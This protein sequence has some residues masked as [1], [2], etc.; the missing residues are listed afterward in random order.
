MGLVKY[1][2]VLVFI[3]LILAALIL[4][5][6]L[7]QYF[8]VLPEKCV[9]FGP[10]IRWCYGIWEKEFWKGIWKDLSYQRPHDLLTTKYYILT[11]YVR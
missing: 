9:E 7:L 1:Y 5:V 10:L 6:G 8:D 3:L 11:R 2:S 4:L